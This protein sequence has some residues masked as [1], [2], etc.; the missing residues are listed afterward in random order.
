MEE[1]FSFNDKKDI[2][3]MELFEEIKVSFDFKNIFIELGS[4]DKRYVKLMK[5]IWKKCLVN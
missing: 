4:L 3:S 2:C 1:I 5:T